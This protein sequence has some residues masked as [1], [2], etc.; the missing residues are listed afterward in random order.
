MTKQ[1]IEEKLLLL[2]AV[3]KEQEETL[4]R[5]ENDLLQ[6]EEALAD[7][8]SDCVV[9][10]VDGKNEQERKARLFRATLPERDTLHERTKRRNCLRSSRDGTLRE[11]RV[12]TAILTARGT[13][14][15]HD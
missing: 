4:A 2:V 11:I 6:A 13:E 1:E 5:A 12:L 7:V 14:N 8:E 10:G 9:G 15:E 3:Y